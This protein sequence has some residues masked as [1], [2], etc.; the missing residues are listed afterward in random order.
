MYG[1]ALKNLEVVAHV[2]RVELVVCAVLR[3]VHHLH[4]AQ[5]AVWIG[6]NSP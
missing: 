5:A 2:E 3:V 1:H 4:R 6:P